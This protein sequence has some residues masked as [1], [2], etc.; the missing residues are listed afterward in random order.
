MNTEKTAAAKSQKPAGTKGRH[1]GLW[2]DVYDDIFSDFDPRPFASRNI[3][4]DFLAEINKRY[5]EDSD[6]IV[7]IQ[8][9]MPAEKRAPET[10][11]IIVK[12]IHG[13]FRKKHTET[14][15][16]Q[17]RLRRNGILMTAAGMLILFAAGIVVMLD[18]KSLARNLLLVIFEPAGWFLCWTG[19]DTFVFSRRRQR[20]QLDFYSRMVKC[21]VIFLPIET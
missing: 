8:L 17:N 7:E 2:L 6:G 15:A 21:R 5:R 9:L 16:E 20:P 12:R 13:Y 18:S 11:E 14:G 1:I 10:E 4:D 3:S 19:L